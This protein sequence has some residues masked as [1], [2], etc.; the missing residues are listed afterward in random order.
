M[1][2]CKKEGCREQAVQFGKRYCPEH[3]KAYQ[4]KQREY[5]AIQQ[6]L[7]NCAGCGEKLSKTRHD[8]G[9]LECGRCHQESLAARMESEERGRIHREK[10]A[11]LAELDAC[12]TVTQLRNYIRK[13]LFE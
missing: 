9:E 3:L 10:T 1:P 5:Q 2:Q 7:R 13:H 11:R 8:A 12:D 4:M 6:T